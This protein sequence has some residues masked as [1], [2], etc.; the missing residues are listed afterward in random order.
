MIYSI[1]WFISVT[2]YDN[3]KHT[4]LKRNNHNITWLKTSSGELEQ[5]CLANKATDIQLTQTYLGLMVN[6]SWLP[7]PAGR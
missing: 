6:N 7:K 5:T 4:E 2:S 3:L 1:Y